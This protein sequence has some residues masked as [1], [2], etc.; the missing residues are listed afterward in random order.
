MYAATARARG[1]IAVADHRAFSSPED[2]FQRCTFCGKELVVLPN[3][4]RG[5]AC[6]DCRSLLGYEEVPCPDC[7]WSVALTPVR[8]HCHRCGWAP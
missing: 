6:F 8:A 5:G 3:D 2:R 7:G 4:Q 1:M